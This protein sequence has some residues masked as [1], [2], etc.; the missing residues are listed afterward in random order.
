MRISGLASGIDTESMIK[1]LMNA[2]R[3]PLDKITKKKQYTEWQRDDYRSVN[4]TLF[5]FR[6]LTS[7]SMLRQSTFIKK[8]V[9]SSAPDEISVK[10]ISSVS[11]F[12]GKINVTQ[13]A[14]AA[15]MQSKEKIPEISSEKDLTKKFSELKISAGNFTIKAIKADG[16]LDGGYVV[17]I[18]A[19]STM[20]SVIDDINK[21]SGVTVFYDTYEGKLAFTAKNSGN[22][23]NSSASNPE[24]IFL[25]TTI[26]P[27]DKVSYD[28]LKVDANNI[29]ASETKPSSG[30]VGK[31]AKFT[32]NG[33]ETERTSNTFNINGYEITLKQA[34][35]KDITF[36]SAPDVDS[37]LSSVTKFVDE[38]NKL[39]EELNT[40]IREPKYR[41]F[42]PLTD[43]ERE[44][45]SEDQI[46]KWEEKA[47]SGTL[48]NDSTISSVLNKM[49][50]S[51]RTSVSGVSGA[52]TIEDIGINLS[53]NY[54]E[55][56][57]LVIDEA[58][59]REAISKDPNEVYALFAA[60]GEKDSEKGLARR[61]TAAIDDARKQIIAKAGTDGT[62]VNNTFTIG[63]LLDGYNTQISKFEDR[64]TAMENRY[65]K[66]FTAMETAI[67]KANSQSS[68]L[69]GMFSTN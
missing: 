60:N 66:Q 65:W 64:L 12:T 27:G 45:L 61:V 55:N 68:Y 9:T 5:N 36:S 19:N 10:N 53:S 2:H 3:I 50:S 6:T 17:E 49:R 38:Y 43:E 7:D 16:T 67:Q 42:E 41:D 23:K 54:L 39:I 15:T 30:T 37:I 25:G 51:L 11:D 33:L 34:S 32:Y 20:Q 29:T 26:N 59:L 47:R 35:Q 44:A 52:K 22:I 1:E 14:E 21:N 18:N 46:K 69:A 28:F 24:I 58:K 31:N 40:K 56:G 63:R 57:K 4:R 48:R 8:T 13:L 62:T